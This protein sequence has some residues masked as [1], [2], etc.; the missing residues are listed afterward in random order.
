LK[1]LTVPISRRRGIER[2]RRIDRRL[3]SSRAD[4]AY[5]GKCPWLDN[6][7]AEHQRIAFRAIIADTDSD[8]APVLAAA[9]LDEHH[10]YWRVEAGRLVM[11][12]PEAFVKELRLLLAASKRVVVVDPYFRAD[13]PTKTRALIAFC[14]GAGV[15]ASI[16]V[17]FAEERGYSLCMRDAARALPGLLPA[18]ATVRLHCWRERPG[19]PRLHNRYVLP[20]VGGVQFGDG[21]EGGDEGQFDRLSILDRTSYQA[22]W[23]QY[24]GS[25]PAFEA[26]GNPQEFTG[27]RVNP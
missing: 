18:G 20:D 10:E 12:T 14:R 7:K 9:T 3:F 11:R 6:A 27:A 1:A 21:I 16:E 19:G 25:S 15:G 5:D 22:L 17:H 13:Q 24:L 26:A 2:L 8:D 4:A 23:E